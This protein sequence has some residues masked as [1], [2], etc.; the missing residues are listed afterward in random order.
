MPIGSKP[1][2]NEV[3][4]LAPVLSLALTVTEKVP[5]ADGVPEIRPDELIASPVGS[6]LAL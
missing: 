2:V 6:P 1:Q 4:P 5:A 3:E